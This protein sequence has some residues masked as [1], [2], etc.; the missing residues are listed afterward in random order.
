MYFTGLWV[1]QIGIK[2][3]EDPAAS[4]FR[5]QNLGAFLWNYVVLRLSVSWYQCCCLPSY[6]AS[7]HRRPI[8]SNT[9][10]FQN[11]RCHMI[12]TIL[13][14]VCHWPP[15][16]STLT[17]SIPYFCNIYFIFTIPS[18]CSSPKEY[19]ICFSFTDCNFYAFPVSSV[20]AVVLPILSTL[21]W[22][23]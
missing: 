4:I 5:V 22:S 17:L 9:Q 13:T 23:F 2:V 12:I 3:L 21:V 7:H 11:I 8:F 18:V 16:C 20:C 10:Y 19:I 6:R 15:F 1:W 14:K